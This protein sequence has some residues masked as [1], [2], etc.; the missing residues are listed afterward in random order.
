[1]EPWTF[2]YAADI[3]VGS[4]KSF[5]FA[6]AWNENWAT[7]RKQ[8]LDINPDLL[9]VGGDL[10]RDG[11]L[12]EH[13][14]ELVEI[15]GD[16]DA[17]P[18]PYHVTPGNM[19]T[20]NKHTRI[21][22]AF[23]NRDDQALNITSDQM[24]QFGDVFGPDCWT[25]VHKDVRFSSF[26]S[27]L[28]GSGL[29][30]EEALW[31]WLEKQKEQPRARYHVWMTHYAIFV[32]AADESNFDITNR[33]HYHDWY[34]GIDE[35]WRGQLIDVFKATGATLVLSGHIHCRRSRT[36]DGIEYL[37]GPATCFP[38]W[39]GRWPDGDA[40]LG[41][42]RY[43]VDDNGMTGT[44]VPLDQVSTKKGYGPGGHPLPEARD[45]SIAWEK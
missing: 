22:G 20:G 31:A 21:Q 36:V 14:Y 13:R 44:F 45:Y 24:E 10:T 3:Q 26:C 40:T 1:M 9:L 4:P 12:P 11:S 15:K 29:P 7:A 42:M 27:M 34:F 5:R 23:D 41:F 18:F 37:I 17:L 28:P 6:P 39:A 8:I 19:D 33:D 32:D 30:E 25:F 2:V 35:P 38:Q 16:L 43:D